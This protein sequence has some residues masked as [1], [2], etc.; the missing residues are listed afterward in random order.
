M[1]IEIPVD[2]TPAIEKLILD[3]RY[4]DEG[5][6]VAEGIRLVLLREQ[7]QRDVQ[8]GLDELNAGK[9]IDAETVYAE[10]RRRIKAIEDGQGQ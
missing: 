4:R 8:A 7:L 3:G 2:F 6:I 10:A 5:E 1:S 9:R